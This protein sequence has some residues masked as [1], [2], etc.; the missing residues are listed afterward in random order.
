MPVWFMRQAGRS[1]PEYKQVRV[2]ISMLDSCA[3]P[4]LVTEITLQPV[5]RY[6]V[7]A[8]IFYSDIM[9]PLKAAGVD[10]D[11]VPGTGPVIAEPIRTAADLER[12]RLLSTDQIP[13]VSEAVRRLVAELG[14]RPLIGFAGA[15][16]TLASY[17]VE[18]GPSKDYARTKA[19]MVS[20]PDV[21]HDLCERLAQ[22]SATF[23]TAQVEAG[24]SAVQLFDSWVGSLS[25]ADYTRFVQPHSAQRAGGDRAARGAAD[26]LRGRHRRAA[27]PDG[28]GR[29][30]RGRGGLADPVWTRRTDGSVTGTRVQG[31]LDP[32]L[33]GAPWPVVA[34][35]TRAVITAG[36]SAPG[37]RVQPGSRGAAGHGSGGAAAHRRPGARGGRRPPPGGPGVTRRGRDRRRRG[38]R[39][40]LRPGRGPAAVAGGA[41]GAAAGGRRRG[42]AARSRA[43][44]SGT[45]QV[46]GG[47]ESV[48]VRRPEAPSLIDEL[49]LHDLLV[50]PTDAK[51]R[52]YVDGR[53]VELPPSALGV[54]ADLEALAG[55]LTPAGLE[56]ARR[57]PSLPA[58]PLTDD[59]PIGLLLDERFGPEVTD[60][61]LEPLLGGVYAGQSRRLSF[62]AVSAALFA[63]AR[64][65]GALSGHAAQLRR[66]GDGPVFGG[67]DGGIV[68]LVETL[69]RS[70]AVR[71]VPVQTS[72]TVREL[73]ATA[74]RIPPDGRLDPGPAADHRA[75][76]RAGHARPPPPG[77]C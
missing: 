71:G 54:P 60:R 34:E 57:E 12:V 33:L 49:G 52:V 17:L 43:S 1:L 19:L 68:A 74:G 31:N 6:G 77:G 47:A 44:G 28:R 8:A 42:S 59:V 67:L 14:E 23:L 48:L 63:K 65:G 76:G 38:R 24:A 13:Y 10:L 7:D 22:I 72:T 64:A 62:R 53:A 56:R 20:R 70:L 58:P 40:D 73:A 27:A 29:R 51:P 39:R 4:D 18:G 11:I 36:A 3:R 5:R 66:P 45:W 15:P 41:V 46:D 37:S 55:L 25:A 30:R 2:G 26:P 32:A 9:V 16:F 61:L 75:R 21:W 35:R 50:H 69:V